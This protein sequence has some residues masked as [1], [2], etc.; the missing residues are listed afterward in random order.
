MLD[1]SNYAVIALVLFSIAFVLMVLATL[2]L[3]RRDTDTFASIP[4][5]DNVSDFRHAPLAIDEG[6]CSETATVDA[7]IR[8]R[9]E[10]NE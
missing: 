5:T 4:L 6:D 1:Y 10:C 3:P 2:R 8:E 7:K 9:T